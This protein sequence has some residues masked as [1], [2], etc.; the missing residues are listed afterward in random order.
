MTC[1][2]LS[3]EIGLF[4]TPGDGLI[5]SG[6]HDATVLLW[7]WSGRENKVVGLLNERQGLFPDCLTDHK[8]TCHHLV[9]GRSVSSVQVIAAMISLCSMWL[10]VLSSSTTV[11]SV[12]PVAVLTGHEQSVVCVAVS[13]NLGLVISGAKCKHL[14]ACITFVCKMFLQCIV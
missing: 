14:C 9:L 7:R 12:T 6:S 10:T 4:G 13:F 3:P 5:A 8:R 2:T 11:D 1:I